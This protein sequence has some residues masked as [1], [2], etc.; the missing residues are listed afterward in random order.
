MRSARCGLH[1]FVQAVF[2]CEIGDKIREKQEVTFLWR[3][4][5]RWEIISRFFQINVEWQLGRGWFNQKKLGVKKVFGLLR[6]INKPENL[7]EITNILIYFNNNRH[8]MTEAEMEYKQKML[9][10]IKGMGEDKIYD[11]LLKELNNIP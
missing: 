1:G 11:L 7:D 4:Y 6:H 9:E 3:I 10:K 8:T 2:I 5:W